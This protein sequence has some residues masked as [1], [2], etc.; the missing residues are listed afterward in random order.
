MKHSR[1]SS[2]E[3]ISV[4]F[5][6]MIFLHATAITGVWCW[7]DYHRESTNVPR[8]I[9]MSPADFK[10]TLSS[11]TPAVATT[12]SAA[13][14][15]IVTPPPVK[16]AAPTPSGLEKKK[17]TES[18][19]VQKAT[20]VA[21]PPQ[22]HQ[23]EPL[24]DTGRTP[25][26]AQTSGPPKPSANRSI[27]LR[28]VPDKRTSPTRFGPPAPPITNPTLL[29]MARLNA[30]RP[31]PA[32]P[33]PLGAPAAI[34][35]QDDTSLDAVDEAV[36]D[37]FLA[38]WTAPPIDAVPTTQ[39]EARLT[40]SIGKNGNVLKS[41]MSKFSGSHSLDESI[42][43][44]VAKVKKISLALPANFSKDSYDLELNFLLLP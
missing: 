26:F 41:Q 12:A 9:W 11:I 2:L 13:I 18:A 25:L 39:R 21:A 16:P 30:M 34:P 7:W 14:T 37:A 40:L 3:P 38:N 23:M 20:L 1:T 17:R 29:D 5:F 33:P 22:E 32:A 28:R 43:E 10:N 8:L 4:A 6:I 36:N 19:M 35:I 15:T 27:T 24:P 44:A 42:I 31:S